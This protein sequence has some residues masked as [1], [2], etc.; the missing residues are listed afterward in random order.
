MSAQAEHSA[1]LG[2][3][4]PQKPVALKG[5]DMSHATC[6]R[7]SGVQVN[8][9]VEV[10]FESLLSKL[11]T[12]NI[13]PHIPTANSTPQIGRAAPRGNDPARR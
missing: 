8:R 5:H 9:V 11:T 10:N 3:R 1:A 4:F 13:S 12:A 2:Q 7:A 6:T